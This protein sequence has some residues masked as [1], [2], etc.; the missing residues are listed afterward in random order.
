MLR[1]NDAVQAAAF[2]RLVAHLQQRTDVQNIDLMIHGGF[3][4][5]CLSDWLAEAA[6]DA[7]VALDKEAARK[8]VYGMSYVVYN[9][10]H[11][12]PATDAQLA[13]MA[14]SVARN[15]RDA[16]LDAALDAGFP[17]SDPPSQTQPA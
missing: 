7:G 5:N 1:D 9:A 16:A 6:A 12:T 11:Q 4:R 13:A 2:R 8:Q 15:R 10:R 17:A 3:C 14:A